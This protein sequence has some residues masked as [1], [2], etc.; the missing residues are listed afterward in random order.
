MHLL[1]VTGAHYENSA[2]VI[3]VPIV[4]QGGFVVEDKRLDRRPAGLSGAETNGV[5]DLHS[6]G[7]DN[8]FPHHDCEI[9]QSCCATGESHFARY[10]FHARFLQVEG[11]KMSKSKG[12]FFTLRDMIERGATP[13]AVRLELIRTH[14][15]D[16]ANFTFQGLKDAQRQIEKL[17]RLRDWLTEHA[18]APRTQAGP[19]P[20][21]TALLE[22]TECVASDINISG[23]LGALNKGAN[24]YNLSAAPP[25]GDAAHGTLAD[26]LAA[27]ERMDSVLGV[28][29]LES[30][31]ATGDDDTARYDALVAERDAAK[32]AKDWARADAIRDELKADGIVLKDSPDGTTW[33]REVG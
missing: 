4:T 14:Y 16:N 31:V 3:E 17:E 13:A 12:N 30:E 7:E 19:G 1:D 22:F 28:L 29:D 10:W 32:A 21:E 8:I 33:S 5:I 26:E 25:A 18:A 9:A 27:L 20:L 2:I 11:E 24:Q 23:A 15:R 6:G